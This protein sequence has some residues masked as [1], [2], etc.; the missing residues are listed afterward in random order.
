LYTP[1]AS[2]AAGEGQKSAQ[3]RLLRLYDERVALLES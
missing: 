2:R 3:M 1:A